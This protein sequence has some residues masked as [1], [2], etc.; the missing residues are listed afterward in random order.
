MYDQILGEKL[1]SNLRDIS[2]FTGSGEGGGGGGGTAILQFVNLSLFY[3]SSNAEKKFPPPIPPKKKLEIN[4][5]IDKACFCFE[6]ELKA[7]QLTLIQF[8]RL[9]GTVQG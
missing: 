1:W 8:G 3:S 5:I 4:F 6:F 2:F 7:A 9:A